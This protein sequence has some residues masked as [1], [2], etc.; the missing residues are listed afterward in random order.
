MSGMAISWNAL[1]IFNSDV[2]SNDKCMPFLKKT[3]DEPKFSKF[4][5]Q[6]R[7]MGNGISGKV[8]IYKSKKIANFNYAVKT[9]HAKED[10]DSKAEYREKVLHEYRILSSLHNDY[11]IRVFKFEVSIPGT[12]IKLYLEAGS[13]FSSLIPQLSKVELFSYW[14]QLCFGVLYLHSLDICHRDLKIEN[15]V[16]VNNTLKIIDFVTAHKVIGDSIGLVGSPKYAAP[17]TFKYLN[18]DGKAADVWSIGIL[19]YYFAT[20]QFPWKMAKLE[21]NRFKSYIDGKSILDILPNEV[22]DFIS[23][24]LEVN[25]KKRVKISDF[26]FNPWFDSITIN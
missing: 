4:D 6:T 17:E 22:I 24:V 25:P 16:L 8:E 13:D 5:K 21:D 3:I 23:G 11:I 20:L 15:L 10:F 14:K 2:K 7:S 26:F 1:K 12:T 19:F 9:Y 18:Y